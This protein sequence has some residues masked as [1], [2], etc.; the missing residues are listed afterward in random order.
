MNNLLGSIEGVGVYLDNIVIYLST[1]EEHFRIKKVFQKL[2]GAQLTINLE[3]SQF[4]KAIVRYLGFEEGRGQIAPV[5]ANIEGVI[6]M[7]VTSA[8]ENWWPFWH[9]PDYWQSSSIVL[10]TTSPSCTTQDFLK[11]K[12]LQQTSSVAMVCPYVPHN[13]STTHGPLFKAWTWLPYSSG[14]RLFDIGFWHSNRFLEWS[15]LFVDRFKDMSLKKINIWAN[16]LDMPFYY[17]REDGSGSG[18]TLQIL[19][20]LSKWLHHKYTIEGSQLFNITV[21]GDLLERGEMDLQINGAVQTLERN[22]KYLISAPLAYQGFSLILQV[23]PPVPSWQN[24]VYPF[25]WSVWL[26]IFISVIFTSVAFHLLYFEHQKSFIT[27]ALTVGQVLLSNALAKVPESWRIRCFLLPWWLGS[28]VIAM[29]YTCNLIAILTVPVFPAMIKT[30]LELAESNF[31]L[32]MLDYGEFV[33]EALATSDQ[34]VFKA[35]GDKLHMVPTQDFMAEMGGEQCVERVL[36]GTDAHLEAYP[37]VKILYDKLGIGE[38]VYMVKERLYASYVSL[39]FH[40][41]VPWKYKYDIG[42]EKLREA[43]LIQKWYKQHIDVFLK[44]SVS[45]IVSA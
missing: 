12:F 15:D 11:T 5:A 38:K 1:W 43:G 21:I 36:S 44:D 33:P 7:V 26:A 3:K 22:K 41:H 37:Y 13:A 16:T 27:N 34:P 31:R 25:T 8:E 24:I 23:P 18:Q 35:L 40:K 19:D 42:M 9:P 30:L 20:V 2:R 29:S 45:K 14:Q 17:A 39:L 10:V 6:I 4:G 28:W 32:C